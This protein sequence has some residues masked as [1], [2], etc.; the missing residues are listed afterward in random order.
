MTLSLSEVSLQIILN[1][2]TLLNLLINILSSKLFSCIK[3]FHNK[4][5][6]FWFKTQR[7]PPLIFFCPGMLRTKVGHRM[8][9][10]ALVRHLSQNSNKLN[11]KLTTFGTTSWI[12]IRLV[13][14]V[15]NAGPNPKFTYRVILILKKIIYSI[16]RGVFKRSAYMK[17]E[18]IWAQNNVMKLFK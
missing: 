15:Q 17:A 14:R 1:L 18:R 7:V 11:F 12:R 5:K 10:V 6:N 2:L 8:S 4:N 16:W 9:S 13:H 3:T